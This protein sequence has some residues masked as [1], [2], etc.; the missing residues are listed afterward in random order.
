MPT[1]Q[2]VSDYETV[3]QNDGYND[4]ELILFFWKE[5]SDCVIIFRYTALPLVRYVTPVDLLL[6]KFCESD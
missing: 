3:K 6:K 2:N 5:H 1:V 4:F